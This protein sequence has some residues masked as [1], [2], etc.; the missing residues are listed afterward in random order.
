MSDWECIYKSAVNEDGSLFFPERLTHEFLDS[1]RK[2]MGTQVFN[3][4]Y[5][6]IVIGGEDKPFKREWIKYYDSLPENIYTY[7][8]LDP[9][10]SQT[11]DA[12][13]TALIV[14]SVDEQM[15]WYVRVANRYKITPT[16]VIGKLFDVSHEFSPM[17]IGVEDVAFQKVLLYNVQ[18]EMQRRQSF[19][20]VQGVKPSTT[21]TKEGKILGL[22]P[23]F[24]WGHIY[25]NRGLYDLENEIL[26]YAGERSQ[27]DDVIDALASIDQIV[28]YPSPMKEQLQEVHPSHP[29]YEKWYRSQLYKRNEGNRT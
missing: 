4:Q 11:V 2:H 24:E 10:I 8:F 22:V 13:Y 6:N 9:A 29:D 26:D 25:L 19:I 14:V 20:P 28:T 16:E 27:H 18:D 3:N 21:R 15:N 5:L 17:I 12:D 23:R 7:V 1:A